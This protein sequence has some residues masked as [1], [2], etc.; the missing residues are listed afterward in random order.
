MGVMDPAY[1]YLPDDEPD[2]TLRFNGESYT[3]GPNRATKIVAWRP[4]WANRS[5][6][7]PDVIVAPQDIPPVSVA[8]TF[9][10]SHGKWGVCV[11]SGPV[12]SAPGKHGVASTLADQAVVD[13]AEAKYRQTTRDWAERIL[14]AEA[15]LNAKRKAVGIREETSPEADRARKWLLVHA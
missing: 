13:R 12:R 3:L 14:F 7:P 4:E 15:D 1:V 8:R 5:D 6:W 11:V 10:E 9:A 2:D